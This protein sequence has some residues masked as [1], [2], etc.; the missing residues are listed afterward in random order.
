MLFISA[1]TTTISNINFF[2][3]QVYFLGMCL[4]LDFCYL[5]GKILWSKW[6]LKKKKP[7]S[8]QP[9]KRLAARRLYSAL[10]FPTAIRCANRFPFRGQGQCTTETSPPVPLPIPEDFFHDLRFLYGW[11][12]PLVETDIVRHSATVTH[13]HIEQ[14]PLQLRIPG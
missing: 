12:F 10:N 8:G 1:K 11:I 13:E 4:I 7:P 3:S 5:A 9:Q 14:F 2:I 6:A